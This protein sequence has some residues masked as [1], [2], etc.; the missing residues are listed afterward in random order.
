M[1]DISLEN[2]SEEQLKVHVMAGGTVGAIA[3]AVTTPLDV[4]KT[5]SRYQGGYLQQS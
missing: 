2:A 3:G 5:R 1:S 4:V